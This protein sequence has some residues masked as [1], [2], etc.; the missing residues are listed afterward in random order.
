[1]HLTPGR[2]PCQHLIT[3]LL[4]ARCSSWRSA[5]CVK[6]LKAK[7]VFYYID[8]YLLFLLELLLYDSESVV[9]LLA[10]AHPGGPGKRAVKRLWCGGGS[11]LSE[12]Y[13]HG[14]NCVKNGW[15]VEMTRCWC[16]CEW[17]SE[18]RRLRVCCT[19]DAVHE[20]SD[21]SAGD[22]ADD[23][24]VW[25]TEHEDGNDWRH[26]LVQQV[27]SC[28]SF[29]CSLCY[30]LLSV[31][32]PACRSYT[33]WCQKTNREWLAVINGA[34]ILLGITAPNAHCNSVTLRRGC[35]SIISSSFNASQ[36]LDGSLCYRL[37]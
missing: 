13:C 1:M 33:G 24:G 34:T 20:Q 25:E 17:V 10:L 15:L 18:W 30:S 31:L 22:S 26:E 37:K 29:S 7:Y 28:L 14:S 32:P 19:D 9:S 21:W 3:K 12:F 16:C 5:N 23:A 6:G 8:I 35:S 11:L 2:W 36:H 4:Q 27:T